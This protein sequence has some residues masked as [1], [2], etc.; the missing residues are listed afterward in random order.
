MEFIETPIFTKSITKLIGDD[1]Y[2]ALQEELLENPKKG[3]VIP[4]S[5]GLR[6]LRFRTRTK[7]KSGGIRA[8]YY[9]MCENKIY[10][11]Y[12]YSKTETEDLTKVQIKQLKGLLEGA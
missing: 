8:I 12:A 2:M 3:S 4:G 1:L 11:L 5:G 9:M 10:M 6:K 7:G